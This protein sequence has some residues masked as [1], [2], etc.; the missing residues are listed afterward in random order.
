MSLKVD[1]EKI[2]RRIFDI[3]QK[4]TLWVKRRGMVKNYCL[5]IIVIIVMVKWTEDE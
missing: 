3:I 2:A 1:E 4:R 5:S